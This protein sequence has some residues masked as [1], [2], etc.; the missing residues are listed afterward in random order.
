MSTSDCERVE[1]GAGHLL[2]G[3]ERAAAGEHDRAARNSRCSSAVEQL[4]APVDRRAQRALALRQVAGAAGEERQPLLEPFEQL[5]RRERLHPRGGELERER[6]VVEAAADRSRRPRRPRSRAR[7]PA[8]GRGRSRPPPRATNGGTGYSCS[9]VRRSGSR[10]VT[11]SVEIRAGR[12]QLGEAAGAPRRPAR[13]CRGAAAAR[14]SPIWAARSPR[15]AERL[16]RR[17]EHERRVANRRER[18]PPDA[19]GEPVGRERRPT[20]ARGASCPCRP[21]PVS[22]SRRRRRRSE[23]RAHLGELPLAAEEGRRR[24]RQVRPVQAPKRRELAVAELVEPLGRAQ[25][26][27]SVLAEVA[28]GASASTSV[29]VEA[30]ITTWPPCA[31]AAIRAARCTS[32]P[33]VPLQAHVRRPRVDAH[34]H[35]D[36]AGRERLLALG[37]CPQRAGRRRER[38]EE[39]VSLRVHLDAAVPGECLAERLPVLG[40]RVGVGPRASAS[41]SLVEPSMSVN[42][43]VTV[44]DGRSR[45]GAVM[46]DRP[47]APLESALVRAEQ[48]R[49]P[50]SV[51]IGRP[52][53]ER[54]RRRPERCARGPTIAHGGKPTLGDRAVPRLRFDLDPIRLHTSPHGRTLRAFRNLT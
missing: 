28:D 26:L 4:V 2:G 52:L 53:P 51:R 50:G 14:L 33:D 18:H 40:Q 34:P 37:G 22:V 17:V 23:E 44:P 5:R 21:A 27:E 13:S 45:T 3:L 39:R 9:P 42:R 24:H 8:P 6:Q 7:P 46:A 38:V 16:R 47:G 10:L 32:A 31:A 12:E 20:G 30:E 15:A 25:V 19:V 1:V 54:R 48:R 49:R 36:R 41:R 29:A 11:S 43:K 35:A